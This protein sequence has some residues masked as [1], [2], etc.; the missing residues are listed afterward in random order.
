LE[1][2]LSPAL[3][4][5]LAR[6]RERLS[7]A[8]GRLEA[9]SPLRVLARG[10]SMTRHGRT[11]EVLRRA[12]QVAPGDLVRTTLERAEIVSKITEVRPVPPR[13]EQPKKE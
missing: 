9:L 10:Y 5:S 4:T 8:A 1:P 13:D 12:S 2:R 11:G 6:R 3:R 7:G